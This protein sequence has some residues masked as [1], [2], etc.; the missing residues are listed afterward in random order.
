MRPWGDVKLSEASGSASSLVDQF[1]N[2]VSVTFIDFEVRDLTRVSWDDTGK[3]FTNDSASDVVFEYEPQIGR[4]ST[5]SVVTAEIFLD[6]SED[7][8]VT[9][10]DELSI[11]KQTTNTNSG[12]NPLTIV[13][14]PDHSV[15]CG[16][17]LD[18]D[19]EDT[20]IISNG[21]GVNNPGSS[22]SGRTVPSIAL[23]IN[24]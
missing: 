24:K 7:N 8:F 2:D 19:I 22:I 23:T 21:Q 11:F 16:H 1:A 13:V 3:F 15:R 6:V 17:I 14:P 12:V 4:R 10:T 5:G 18:N 9:N 20:G